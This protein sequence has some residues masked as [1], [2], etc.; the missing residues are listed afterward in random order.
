[1]LEQYLIIKGR[2]LATQR[3]F[4]PCLTSLC[5]LVADKMGIMDFP[6]SPSMTSLIHQPLGDLTDVE[7][8]NPTP[9]LHGP[10]ISP[11]I[12]YVNMRL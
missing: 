8:I 7:G 1:M 5:Y 10:E 3:H 9:S 2:L 4:V 11:I 12:P 6:K